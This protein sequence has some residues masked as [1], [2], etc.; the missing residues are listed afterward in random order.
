MTKSPPKNSFP[1][2]SEIT[3]VEGTEGWEDMY[4]YFT[5]F[6]P[7][8]DERFWFYNSMHFPEP[9]PAFDLV[10]SE[11]PYTAIGAVT[12]RIFAFPTALGI[13]HR[14][15]NGR[16]Y[17]TANA[18][19]DPDVIERRLEIFQKRGAHYYEN[20]DKLCGE[21]KERINK[22]IDDLKAIKVPEL[23]EFED[24]EVVMKA[25]GIGQNHFVRTEYH[26]AIE[27][28]SV[29]WHY[30]FE[31]LMLGYGAY[32]VFFQFAKKIFPEIA[33]QTVAR[34]VCGMDAL[35]FR[36]DDELKKL[37]HLAFDLGI[38]DCFVNDMPA[39]KI[40]KSVAD[41]GEAGE[42]WLAAMEE[43]RE[44]WFHVSTGDGFYHHH[45]SWN[46]DLSVPFA[47]LPHYIA[48]L[49]E[50]RE[51]ERPTAKLK[52][53]RERIIAEYRE[54]IESED[55]LAVFDQMLGL[56]HVVF[57]YVED[58]RFYCEHWFTTL[59]YNKIRE[60][61]EL[62]AR[63][64]VLEDAEDVF[65]L[66][67]T[68]VDQ[69][70]VDVM[71]AWAGGG[72]AMGGPYWK[73]IVERR[74]EILEKLKDWD[75]PPAL[76]P[77]PEQ[78]EDPALQMLWGITSENLD[79]WSRSEEET[80]P[81]ELRGFAASPGVVEGTARVLKNVNDIGTIRD[82]EILV[83]PVTAPSWGPVFGK[84]KAAVSDIGGTMSHAAIVARE[85]GM[86]AVVGTGKA[87]K[88]IKTGDQLRV[89]GDRGIVTILR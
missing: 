87:T 3:D 78:I 89:D 31:F 42:K 83:C 33:D 30:H 28:Y 67:H 40:L 35:M 37:A 81:D 10:T 56:C 59:F 13:E 5:R 18:V 58:H 54:L 45:R 38:G 14:I 48:E 84:L 8:D 47:A 70:L 11:I 51:I 60:F 16:I 29:M 75:P 82:G 2:P 34:M 43:T 53:E 69:A 44:P 72:K 71:L 85:Y 27:A 76:G 32:M 17:L 4:P 9:M 88:K 15:I 49:K 79:S 46:D 73:P 65:Q 80:D 74:K 39:E 66:H 63:W 52:K 25:I 22:L 24:E 50:G 6:T 26:R 1:L 64:D 41:Q 62:L 61:G 68:E 12:T 86:P 21:W 55:D 36:P 23:P 19:T 57:P 77:L 7:E 20:W